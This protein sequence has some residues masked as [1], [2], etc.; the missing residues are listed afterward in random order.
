[1]S[2]TD[3]AKLDDSIPNYDPDDASKY[4]P[5]VKNF[6]YLEH[7][8]D[9]Q[10]HSWG[11]DLKE[12]FQSAATSLY[13]YM[14]PV[15][16][17]FPSDSREILITPSKSFEDFEEA[18]VNHSSNDLYTEN[19]NR[20]LFTWL[21]ECLFLATCDPFFIA[22]ELEIVEFD[23]T[24]FHIRAIL[25]GEPFDI[26]KHQQGTE[27]KAITYSAMKILQHEDEEMDDR[28]RCEVFCIVDI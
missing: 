6:E 21:D 17:I 16:Q 13:N 25:Y 9:I 26:Y 12:S 28:R 15:D 10:L 23:E 2:E 8:A 7:P 14:C 22:R 4:D 11:H 3:N 1:M 24:K 18:E 27:V 20:L 19:L 5:V